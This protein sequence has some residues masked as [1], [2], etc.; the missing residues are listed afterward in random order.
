VKVIALHHRLGGFGGHRYN[1]ARGLIDECRRRGWELD[2]PISVHAPPA[3]V[4]RLAPFARP[5]FDDPTFD[6]SRTFEQ[7][8][9]EFE[10]QVRAHVEP[11]LTADSRVLVTVATQCEACAL[12]RWAQ[13]LPQERIPSFFVLF[14]SD[15]WNRAGARPDER[16]EI[17]AA[18][19]ELRRLSAARRTRFVLTAST[20]GLAA[21][22][23][24]RMGCAVA[25]A[26]AHL[27]YR[28]LAEIARE[29]TTRPLR[30]QPVVGLLGGARP[31]KG[32]H[33]IPDIVAACRARAPVRFLVQAWNEGAGAAVT[34]RIRLLAAEPNVTIV[35]GPIERDAYERAL[36]EIDLLL[37][38]YERVNYR[39]RNSG[40]VAE[41]V[42]AG[43]PCVVPSGTWMAAQIEAGRIAGV[44]YAGDGPSDA[45]EATMRGAGDLAALTR[46][47]ARLAA[48]WRESESLGAWLD[49]MEHLAAEQRLGG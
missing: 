31:E 34:E 1:E 30:A 38:P 22:L 37:C 2:L 33:L 6:F 41:G 5:V 46:T 39:Q 23:S 45:A 14:L 19:R 24:L 43:L 18:G 48:P 16:A 7:R 11:A 12:A 36:A 21:E 8:A 13:S 10:R 35:D 9:D 28:G 49:A 44:V 15:R 4:E 20:P 25:P 29:R 26:P 32:S 40:I 47:A 3:V 42:A 27:N 17:A